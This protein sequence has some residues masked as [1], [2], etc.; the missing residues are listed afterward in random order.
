MGSFFQCKPVRICRKIFR[1]CRIIVLFTVFLVMAEVA[2]LHLIGLPEFLKRPLLQ[3]LRQHGFDAEFT[4][5]HLNWGPV[6]EVENAAFQTTNEASG[7]R[8]SAGLAILA[9]KWDDLVHGRFKVDSFQVATARLQA[10]HAGTNGIPLSLENVSLALVLLSNNVARLDDAV[11]SFRG[12]RICLNGEVTNYLAMQ[13]WKWPMASTPKSPGSN[14]L[15]AS[16][17]ER[18]G[19]FSDFLDQLQFSG[20]PG[21]NLNFSADGAD[22]NSVHG[23]LK[24]RAGG[25][26]TPWGQAGAFQV[27]GAW[28]RILSLADEPILRVRITAA[29]TRT[30]WGTASN[31]VLTTTVSRD[32]QSNWNAAADLSVTGL[33]AR[34]GTNWVR[35]SNLWANGAATLGSTNFLP[36]TLSATVRVGAAQS[37]WGSADGLSLSVQAVPA[38]KPAAEANW[39]VWGKLAPYSFAWQVA[40]TNVLSPR[41]QVEGL[42]AEGRWRAPELIADKLALRLYHR[43]LDGTARLDV[44]SREVNCRVVSDFDPHKASALLT[45]AAARWMSQYDW[46]EPPKVNAEMRLVLPPWTNRPENWRTNLHASVVIAGNFTVGEASF[47]G[48]TVT[49]ANSHFSYSNRVWNLPRLRA[50]RPD[51]QLEMDYTGSDETHEFHF[52]FD[53]RLDPRDAA[54]LLPAAQRHYLEDLDFPLAP[55]IHGQAW[56]VWRRHETISFAG[57]VAATNAVV[58]GQVIDIVSAI[59]NYTNRLLTLSNLRVAKDGGVLRSEWI[60]ADLAS[61][62]VMMTNIGC[63]I[64]PDLARGLM[65]TNVPQFLKIIHFDTPPSIRA[66]GSF[67]VGNPLAT[68]LHFYVRGQHFHWTNLSADKIEGGIDWEGRSVHLT[69][70]EASVYNTGTLVGWTVFD[71]V[72]RRGSS[73]RSDF[74][75]TDIDLSALVKGLTGRTNRLEGMLDG[76]LVLGAPQTTN[77]TT[78]LGHGNIRVHDALLWDIKLFGM[79]SPI[80]DAIAPGA[81][82]SRAHSATATFVITNGGVSSDDLEVDAPGLRILYWGTID[83]SKNIDGRVEADLLYNVPVLGPILSTALLPLSK[84]F[85]YHIGGTLRNPMIE[86]VFIPKVLMMILRPFHTLKSL[87]PPL[88]PASAP[89]PGPTRPPGTTK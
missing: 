18:L 81:G 69:N 63:N 27:Q 4:G 85:E 51:G 55:A 58:R 36:K 39:W 46:T 32:G 66:S 79:L 61:R 65:G 87:L 44:G 37:P 80:L 78:W 71:Y 40:A 86:P 68:D 5:A 29:D 1:W 75:G 23:D 13:R 25:V 60:T 83:M 9:L 7:P 41:L 38:T 62:K 64:S 53:S 20:N 84:L 72:P 76:H 33:A 48:V 54:P 43:R 22:M 57:T 11:F 59:V 28:A 47:R 77:K 45:P 24:F 15:S 17:P 52:A 35:A 3:T 10:P 88:P 56:G 14:A 6:I 26:Q 19:H 30:P 2:Y 8:L 31:V 21:L 73:F 12:I 34:A 67:V 16:L 70:I 42:E 82:R 50:V 49:S 89:A 74:S